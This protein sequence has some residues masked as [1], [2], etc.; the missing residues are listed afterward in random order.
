MTDS[1]V[2]PADFSG[3]L[4][5]R[6]HAEASERERNIRRTIAGVAVLL[7]HILAISVFIYSSRIPLLVRIRTTVPEAIW[8][9][10]QPKHPAK[11]PNP[12]IETP[13]QPEESLPVLT[14]PITLPLIRHSE[15]LAPPANEGLAGLGR[16]LACG[17]SS[18]EYLS[19]LDRQ[20]CRRHPWQF[21]KRPD[22]TIVLEAPAKPVEP[23]PSIADV[24]RH[25]QQTAPPCPI[26]SN[27]PCLGK[28]MH[29][30]PL[31]GQPQPF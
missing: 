28:I 26:L 20:Q 2:D 21:I 4:A 1:T 8:V 31:G 6:S 27:V 12:L 17:A 16:S 30:D 9:L 10:T 24:M 19:V 13:I 18:Y 5:A 29:G 25:E 15:P 22:G 7:L 11:P 23:P 14:A 3:I